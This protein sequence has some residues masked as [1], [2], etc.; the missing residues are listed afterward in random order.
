M[1]RALDSRLVALVAL[2]ALALHHL[3]YLLAHGEAAQVALEREGHAYLELALGPL[4]ALAAAALV[5]SVVR[6]ALAPAPGLW[7]GARATFACLS[8]ATLATYAAQELIEGVLFAGHPSG[9]AALLANGGWV[10]LPLA[11]A[12]GALLL[13]VA[14]LLERADRA[15]GELV[16]AHRRRPA[17]APRSL[18]A[19]R[20]SQTRPA[21]A[22]LSFA[23][24]R[25][26]PPRGAFV[27]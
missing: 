5:A 8:A 27:R 13:L 10:A 20:A 16:R 11:L 2:G 26:P 22:P 12:V 21:P 23:L 14:R 6:R 19:P 9:A 25:R 1:A 3:R 18:G 4:L 7:R 15:L 24:H 17:R